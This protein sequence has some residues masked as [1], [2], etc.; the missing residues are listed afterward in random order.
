MVSIGDKGARLWVRCGIVETRRLRELRGCGVL[1]HKYNSDQVHGGEVSRCGC[2]TL[3]VASPRTCHPKTPSI[4]QEL[5]DAPH[6]A[7]TKH[8]RRALPSADI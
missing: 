6:Q 5:P 1:L 3:H 7:Q 8:R 4:M 2:I